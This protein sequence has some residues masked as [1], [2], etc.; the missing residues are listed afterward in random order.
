MDPVKLI[1]AAAGMA[2][3]GTGSYTYWTSADIVVENL[4]Y[5]KV[6]GIWGRRPVDNTWT[7]YP[8]TYWRSVPGNREVWRVR[9]PGTAIDRFAVKYE[10]AWSVYWDN[11]FGHDYVLDVTAAQQ[12]D[13]I[14]TA[15]IASAVQVAGSTKDGG[16]LDLEILVQNLT[17]VKQVGIRYTTNNWGTY[18]EAFASYTKSYPPPSTPS[19]IS[20]EYWQLALPVGAGR[21]EFAAF[22]RHNGSADWDN[23]FSL[24]FRF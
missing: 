2:P 11:N 4:A 6:V 21:G 17:Y 18:G 16:N 1:R 13:G 20:T 8:G 12:T 3:S 15:V 24:N 23:D 22:Y 19:Q 5:D 14:G 7:L 9:V 10:A